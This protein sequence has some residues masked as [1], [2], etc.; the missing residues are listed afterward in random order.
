M[1]IIVVAV[2]SFA[3]GVAVHALF[4]RADSAAILRR[5]AADRLA[6]VCERSR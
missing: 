6:S 2:F 1:L 3:I 5:Q 4:K